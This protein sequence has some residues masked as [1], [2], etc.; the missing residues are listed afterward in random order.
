MT[1]IERDELQVR[2]N[3]LGNEL[4]ALRLRSHLSG[5]E[6][7]A[8]TDLSQPKVSRIETG[9]VTPTPADV[10][11][12]LS[13]LHV[14]EKV[15]TR[16]VAEAEGIADLAK[17]LRRERQRVGLDGIQIE[18]QATEAIY[19]KFRTFT[20]GLPA[21]LVQTPEYLRSMLRSYYPPLPDSEIERAVGRRVERQAILRDPAKTF[22]F[23]VAPEVLRSRFGDKEEMLVQLTHL[24]ALNRLPN[25]IVRALDLSRPIPTPALHNF[26]IFDS[27]RVV[28]ELMHTE[29]FVSDPIEVE[30]Y[31]GRFDKLL[32]DSLSVEDTTALIDHELSH[33]R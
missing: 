7:A 20:Y 1:T 4:R 12:I 16:L 18:H 24:R 13:Q 29:I 28:V 19:N 11:R 25:V 8:A 27:V 3:R 2:R 31:C 23:I 30:G 33:L 17:N 22:E 9:R 5:E 26:T 6:L 15:T 10:L 32:A 14:S 21:G